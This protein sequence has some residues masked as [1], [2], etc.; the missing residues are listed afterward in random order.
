MRHENETMVHLAKNSKTK[1][2]WISFILCVVLAMV[3]ISLV[4]FQ[5]ALDFRN[6]VFIDGMPKIDEEVSPVEPVFATLSSS[7]SFTPANCK[8]TTK[9]WLKKVQAAFSGNPK[10]KLTEVSIYGTTTICR[11]TSPKSGTRYSLI[12]IRTGDGL[13][14]DG[15]T[16]LN[17]E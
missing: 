11:I 15:K 9:A 2:I 6:A 16:F 13:S 12:M 17:E 5:V 3:V 10:L 7:G 8:P 4:R 14:D 1:W